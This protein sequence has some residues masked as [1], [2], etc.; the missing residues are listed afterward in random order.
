MGT[1]TTTDADALKFEAT[2]KKKITS[3]HYT[4]AMLILYLAGP[5][6]SMALVSS[7]NSIKELDK[8]DEK[9]INQWL[10]YRAK[11]SKVSIS[12][13]F[14]KFLKLG[15]KHAENFEIERTIESGD[16]QQMVG[17]SSEILSYYNATNDPDSIKNVIS[18]ER[19]SLVQDGIHPAILRAYD[20]GRLEKFL[21]EE[22]DTLQ[23]GIDPRAFAAYDSG[24]L[25]E[26]VA[27]KRVEKLAEIEAKSNL[28]QGSR[29][30]LI[31][32]MNKEW[33]YEIGEYDGGKWNDKYSITAQVEN[34]THG[35][36]KSMGRFDI[37]YTRSM[38]KQVREVNRQLGSQKPVVIEI[39]QISDEDARTLRGGRLFES[40]LKDSKNVVEEFNKVIRQSEY[41]AIPYVKD[42]FSSPA[43][44]Y[45][46]ENIS[47]LIDP[48][49]NEGA[50]ENNLRQYDRANEG[51]LL[52]T[53]LEEVKKTLLI[54]IKIR[55]FN[56]ML[57]LDVCKKYGISF[58][59]VDRNF[60]A[61][62]G[63][64]KELL[65]RPEGQ[66][67]DDLKKLV[68]S[69]VEAVK[70][71]AKRNNIALNTDAVAVMANR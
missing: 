49:E 54:G 6:S 21:E 29:E 67:D 19:D 34:I 47:L 37:L 1:I 64:A 35:N 65:K 51:D 50:L 4:S 12:N 13:A 3:W 33:S 28:N 20:E 61:S 71:V 5:I 32:E 43:V 41:R 48:G 15:Q 16:V 59:V 11:N 40:L 14:G 46:N 30:A 9:T 8:N 2:T 62:L 7:E 70:D 45:P 22:K 63:W 17:R 58:A 52:R 31:R 23:T 69:P 27:K 60:P 53:Y 10:S 68:N 24:L 56:N 26:L 38:M 18:T 44:P 57:L 55:S 42:F 25:K 36:A 66:N 39:T